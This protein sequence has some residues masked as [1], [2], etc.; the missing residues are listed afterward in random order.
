MDKEFITFIVVD[1]ID[2]AEIAII[3][4]LKQKPSL[5]NKINVYTILEDETIS[6]SLFKDK[7]K[8]QDLIKLETPF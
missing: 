6:T 5:L 4:L 2:T 3:E 7:L 8:K 1:S